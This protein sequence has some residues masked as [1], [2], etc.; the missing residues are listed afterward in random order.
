MQDKDNH[1]MTNEEPAKDAAIVKITNE[2]E[3]IQTCK[4][5]AEMGKRPETAVVREKNELK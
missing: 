5:L 1:E 3:L 2:Q 4:E